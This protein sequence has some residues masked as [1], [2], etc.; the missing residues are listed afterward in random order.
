MS[1][2][3]GAAVALAFAKEVSVQ[4]I[5]VAA[6]IMAFAE[7][8]PVSVILG[9]AVVLAFAEEVSVSGKSV[10]QKDQYKSVR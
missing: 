10:P 6:V 3:L 1:V 2:T 5:C 8:V 7:E 9:A 4:V